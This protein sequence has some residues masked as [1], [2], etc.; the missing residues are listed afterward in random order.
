MTAEVRRADAGRDYVSAPPGEI[1]WREE[2]CPFPGASVLLLTKHGVLVEGPW[3][4]E[5][6][7]YFI[8]WCPKPKRGPKHPT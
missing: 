4:G 1:Y 6:G 5:L 2:K 7:Q 8:A 3:K